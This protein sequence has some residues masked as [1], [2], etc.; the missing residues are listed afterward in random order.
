MARDFEKDIVYPRLKELNR[1]T[2][3]VVARVLAE[4]NGWSERT[5]RDWLHRLEMAGLVA[6]PGG[7]RSGWRAV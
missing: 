3:P 4:L 6:R 1:Q 2:G 5:T 7:V